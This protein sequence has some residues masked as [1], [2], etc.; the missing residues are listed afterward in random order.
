L[1]IN[2]NFNRSEILLRSARKEFEENRDLIDSVEIGKKLVLGR[3]AIIEVEEK[4]NK[5]YHEINSFSQKTK[6]PQ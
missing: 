4:I 5:V 3:Q 6:N 1:L 2:S